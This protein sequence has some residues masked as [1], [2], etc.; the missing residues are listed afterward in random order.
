[1]CF[2]VSRECLYRFFPSSE[3]VA[4]IKMDFCGASADRGNR[5]RDRHTRAVA[6]LVLGGQVNGGAVRGRGTCRLRAHPRD[7]QA[8]LSAQETLA[9][10]ALAAAA[11]GRVALEGGDLH[12]RLAGA[13]QRAERR[14]HGDHHGIN[15][16]LDHPE[17]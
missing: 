10:H 3:C 7:V 11:L 17:A 13:R 14:R 9:A 16:G 15:G 6:A 5:K 4:V 12:G 1:M 2:T 8:V